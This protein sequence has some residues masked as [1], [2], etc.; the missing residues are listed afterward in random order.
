MQSTVP[1]WYPVQQC[2]SRSRSLRSSAK[3]WGCAMSHFALTGIVKQ[4]GGTVTSDNTQTQTQT[5]TVQVIGTVTVGR[6][7]Q[8]S[9][10]PAKKQKVSNHKSL[11][12]ASNFL[13]HKCLKHM[14]EISYHKW[15]L[16]FQPVTDTWICCQASTIPS[17]LG[18]C[19]S[20]I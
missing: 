18:S 12:S 5:V 15:H 2:S 17:P 6:C 4:K 8:Q 13:D 20:A 9:T 10:T 7:S 11:I 1:Y 19:F 16:K 3:G 14:W